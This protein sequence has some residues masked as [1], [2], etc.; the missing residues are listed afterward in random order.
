M[1]ESPVISQAAGATRHARAWLLA[2]LTF[3]AVRALPNISYPIA[4]DQATYC[5]LGQGLLEGK[6]LYLDFWDNRSPG[7][8]YIYAAIVKLCGA[9]MWCVGLV[10]ILWLLVISYLVFRFTERYLGPGAAAVAVVANASWHV[11][12]GYWQAAQAEPLL[13]VFVFTAFFLMA[14]EGRWPRLRHF[15]AGLVFGAAF[16]TKYNSLAFL[17]LVALVPY[18]NTSTLD[19]APRRLSLLIPW[20]RW[21]ANCLVFAVGF[22]VVVGLVLTYFWGVGSWAAFVED[23]FVVLPRYAAMAL[24]RTPHYW[25]YAVNQTTA[26]IGPWTEAATAVALILAWK[27]GN[28]KRLAPVVAAAALG[29]ASLAVQV[30]FHAYAFE[31]CNPFFAMIWGYLG[32]KAYQALRAL[33]RSFAARGW[34]VARVLVW[35]VFANLVVWPLPEQVLNVAAHY[36]ALA[37]WWRQPETFYASYPWP[38]PISHLPDQMRV[39][40]YLRKHVRAGEGVFVWGSEPLIY[41]LTGTRQPT[42]FVLNLPLVSPWSPAAWREEVVRDL[43]KSPPR[44][45]V[46]ARDDAIPYI[47]YHP[48]D[49]EEFLKLYPELATFISDCYEPVEHLTNFEIYC[50]RGSTQARVPTSAESPLK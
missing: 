41:F 21:L 25:L 6:H 48:W 7:L 36:Q 43:K 5:V 4:R 42:R 9:E 17:P 46:V 26:L 33:A 27:F 19:A 39:I 35:V 22:G 34:R 29:Y 24:E 40:S 38:I 49:S 44:F 11:W 15:L 18:V 16:W 32:L 20:R 14:G 12:A 3:V 13:M 8:A 2:A 47:A 37:A 10:D 28:L 31:T 50:R 1:A 30:R 23:Q 45:L